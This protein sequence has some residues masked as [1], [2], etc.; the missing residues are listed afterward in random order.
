M[1]PQI[2]EAFQRYP[3]TLL[4]ILGDFVSRVIEQNPETQRLTVS[5]I[6]EELRRRQD[7]AAPDG[8]SPN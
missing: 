1:D 6:Y 4:K 5:Y 2:Q 7:E 8:H 3:T